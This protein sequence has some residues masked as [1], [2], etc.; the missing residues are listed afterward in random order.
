MCLTHALLEISLPFLRLGSTREG[1]EGLRAREMGSVLAARK[2]ICSWRAVSGRWGS[3]THS[4][5]VG[6]TEML[7]KCV[8]PHPP[9]EAQG[10][11]IKSP[12]PPSHGELRE[13][14]SPGEKQN[15]T[16]ENRAGEERAGASPAAGGSALGQVHSPLT[17]HPSKSAE[18]SPQRCTRLPRDKMWARGWEGAEESSAPAPPAFGSSPC[19]RARTPQT[20]SPWK[21]EPPQ[22]TERSPCR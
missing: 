3:R 17:S 12:L 2:G 18:T 21:S 1:E 19:S 6:H 8:H 14:L 11:L 5:A 15:K 22:T 10:W 7:G 4:Q 16:P 20:G 13:P 9:R